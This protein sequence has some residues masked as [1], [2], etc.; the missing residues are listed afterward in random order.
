[1]AGS[2]AGSP[3]DGL[4]NGGKRVVRSQV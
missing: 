1:V 2:G 4:D 3:G